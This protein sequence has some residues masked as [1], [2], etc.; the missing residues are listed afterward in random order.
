MKR[1][2][3]LTAGA[4][5]I[6]VD[7]VGRTAMRFNDGRN[8]PASSTCA[9]SAAPYRQRRAGN[10]SQY[11]ETGSARRGKIAGKIHFA[12]H[13]TAMTDCRPRDGHRGKGA[14]AH[15]RR[16]ARIDRGSRVRP[17]R[18][19][20]VA[21]LS[22]KGELP[23]RP[24]RDPRSQFGRLTVLPRP[25]QPFPRSLAQ[26][27]GL[28]ARP[29]PEGGVGGTGQAFGRLRDGTHCAPPQPFA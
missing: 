25:G 13:R 21:A 7:R 17:V 26:E 18:L 23:H 14:G 9:S 8:I 15:S 16:D 28:F 11:R 29:T 22:P 19:S 1:R 20:A 24:S 12:F 10:R 6:A 27:R 2:T 4:I 5:K 3:P